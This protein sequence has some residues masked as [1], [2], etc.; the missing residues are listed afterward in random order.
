VT[1]NAVLLVFY[2]E[3]FQAIMTLAAES[4]FGHFVHMHLVRTMGH[5]EYKV[6]ANGALEVFFIH[7]FSMAENNGQRIFGN[8]GEIAAACFCNNAHRD[9]QAG[10]DHGYY[11]QLF[12]NAP[13]ALMPILLY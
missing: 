4:T 2:V 3:C 8:K 6:V 5:L 12:H 9:Q 10:R 13:H 11:K 7:V 1:A